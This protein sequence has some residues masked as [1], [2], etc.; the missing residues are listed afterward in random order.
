MISILPDPKPTSKVKAVI[1]GPTDSAY[2]KNALLAAIEGLARNGIDA[3]DLTNDTRMDSL[4]QA[5]EVW[6]LQV[7]STLPAY[8]NTITA[9]RVRRVISGKWAKPPKDTRALPGQFEFFTQG[10]AV[11]KNHLL[12]ASRIQLTDT[13]L[14]L[15]ETNGFTSQLPKSTKYVI[16]S[17]NDHR[18]IVLHWNGAGKSDFTEDIYREV[19]AEIKA[20]GLTARPVEV[21]AETNGWSGNNYNFNQIP[22]DILAKLGIE[23]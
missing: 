6:A 1:T 9:E 5:E 12:A 21:Y 22:D 7:G 16:G 3:E 13:I 11:D 10:E 19:F 23:L 18:A 17:T 4:A 2:A 8:A 15:H 14:S 20:L